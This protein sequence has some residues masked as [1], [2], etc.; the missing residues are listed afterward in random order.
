M[1]ISKISFSLMIFFTIVGSIY[2]STTPNPKSQIISQ[3]ADHN[4]KAE[5]MGNLGGFQVYIINV[6]SS[7]FLAIDHTGLTKIK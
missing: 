1:L 7:E 2:S 5:Y 4:Y 6:D 3:S